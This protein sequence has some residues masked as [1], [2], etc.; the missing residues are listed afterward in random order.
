MI[1]VRFYGGTGYCG[2][3]YEEYEAFPDDVDV[4]YIDELSQ[5]MAYENAES[6]EYVVT[7]CGESWESDEDRDEYYED[8]LEYCGW[9]YCS[10]EEY[11]ENQ[12]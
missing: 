9:D 12:Q 11:E 8:A 3:D 5:D 10:Q 4:S 2:C 6:F 7:G 1:Y